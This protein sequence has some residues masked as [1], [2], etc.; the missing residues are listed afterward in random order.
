MIAP[1]KFSSHSQILFGAGALEKNK[2][3]IAQMG[4]R[5]LV[6][7]GKH[8]ID[9]PAGERLTYFLGQ[10][11]Q[12]NSWETISGEPTV[13]SLDT[14][15]TDFAEKG[16]EVIV[17]IGGGSVID[18]GKALSAMIPLKGESIQ[19]YLEEVGGK[20]H[21]GSKVPFIAIPTTAGTGAEMTKNA[22][23][24]RPSPQG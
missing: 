9:S 20:K 7:A 3:I 16:I 1:F 15:S 4:K 10:N 24:S 5:V 13:E 6:L 19:N 17:A 12:Y 2:E 22:V 8:F 23:I 21:P 18:T 14:L 11:T